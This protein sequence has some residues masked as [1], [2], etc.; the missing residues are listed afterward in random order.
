MLH[1]GEASEKQNIEF[2]WGSKRRIVGPNKD[3]H[4]YESFTYDGVEYF[5]YDSVYLWRDNQPD[6]DIGKLGKGLSNINFLEAIC[7]KCNVVCTSK[8][9]RN[10]QASGE[11]LRMADYIFYRTFDVG[12]C[13]ISDTFADMIAGTEVVHF[14]NRK[15]NQKL[16]TCPELQANLK[17]K[18]GNSSSFSKGEVTNAR[19]A[20]NNGKSGISTNR[21]AK[22][23]KIPAPSL[24]IFYKN[25][26]LRPKTSIDKDGTRAA[27]IS[28]SEVEN[29]EKAKL[30]EE[31]SPTGISDNRPPKKRKTQGSSESSKDPAKLLDPPPRLPDYREKFLDAKD[32]VGNRRLLKGVSSHDNANNISHEAAAQREQDR[33]TKTDSQIMEVTR[34]PDVDTRNWFKQQSWEERMQR[35]QEKGTLVLLENL[36]PSYTSSEVE[37]LVWN[38]FK[39]K[40]DAKMVQHS[41]F[42]SPHYGQAFVIFKS[43]DAAECAI[44][45]L[46]RKCLMLNGRPIVGCRGTIR[47]PGKPTRFIGHLV[48]PK[49][50]FQRQRE[51]MRD[52]VS[53]SHY[54]QPNTIEFDM[55][56]EWRGLQEKSNLWWE[57]LNKQQAKEIEDLRSRL[58]NP[59]FK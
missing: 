26:T 52:A 46:N 9:R 39:A 33:G 51:E 50:K 31:L 32:S 49:V 3:I 14:F 43:R 40:V 22:E 13:R 30:Y 28:C 47:E 17:E 25:T 53:T 38:A 8:D 57:A 12:S 16:M 19:N 37:D 44:S 21:V 10:P 11:E 42:S 7:G 23:S 35:A 29:R 59:S 48:I 36:D 18:T 5:L 1:L 55:A 58:K 2:S 20:V 41:S 54:S 56:I 45:E 24:D 6:P 27:R 15:N 34:R 4:L